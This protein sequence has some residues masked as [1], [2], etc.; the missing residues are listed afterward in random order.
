LDINNSETLEWDEFCVLTEKCKTCLS[1]VDY[2]PLHEIE[3]VDFEIH[4]KATKGGQQREK[5]GSDQGDGSADEA[6]RS[7]LGRISERVKMM[8]ESAT[9]VD[10]DGDGN[11]EGQAIPY[12]DSD[13]H[14]VSIAVTTVEGGHNSGRSYLHVVEPAEAQKWLDK[15]RACARECKARHKKTQIDAIYGHSMFSLLRAKMRI[16]HESNPFEI[17]IAF[18]IIAGFLTDIAEAQVLAP[19]G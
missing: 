17:L 7:F 1:V 2:I 15:L 18:F 4:L 9:G 3:S 19:E 5:T 11:A 8:V 12:F 10:M 6:P 14:E 13:T 16:V